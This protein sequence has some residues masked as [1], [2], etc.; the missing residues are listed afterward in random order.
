MLFASIFAHVTEK[1]YY[2]FLNYVLELFVTVVPEKH[3]SLF[4]KVLQ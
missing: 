3:V 1:N 4:E 2:F